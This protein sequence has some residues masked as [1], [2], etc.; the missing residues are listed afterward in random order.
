MTSNRNY[1]STSYNVL[2]FCQ[3]TLAD[4]TDNKDN[5][6]FCEDNTSY[7]YDCTVESATL[8]RHIPA[9]LNWLRVCRSCMQQDAEQLLA[10][11]SLS[12]SAHK[13]H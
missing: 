13:T 10:A 4:L 7:D 12:L 2:Y 11:A 5:V 3:A 1:A 6:E 8:Q 9:L